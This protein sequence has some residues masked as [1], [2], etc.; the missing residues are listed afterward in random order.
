MKI[1]INTNGNAEMIDA[2]CNAVKPP[3][4]NNTV[5]AEAWIKPQT[6]LIISGGL[7]IPFVVWIPNT[8]VAESAE[9]MKNV[10]INTI[11]RTDAI[12]ASGNS[13]NA[14]KS[15]ISVSVPS[16][17]AFQI[18]PSEKISRLIPDPPKIVNHS[19]QNSVGTAKTPKMNSRTVRPLET[20]A[21][22]VPTKGDQAI[23]HAQ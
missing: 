17:I 23:H 12:V 15:A 16:P 11:E 6:S 9:V 21:I 18:P 19:A 1:K 8:N 20:R 14:A 5:A 13:F 22:N 10:L 7:S 2:V 3:D 4:H